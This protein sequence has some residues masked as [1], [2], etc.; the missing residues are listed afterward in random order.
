MEYKANAESNGYN[1]PTRR[2]SGGA[3]AVASAYGISGGNAYDVT[4]KKIKNNPEARG[5]S[6]LHIM[7]F[8]NKRH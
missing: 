4:T 7:I 3:G 1:N 8:N 2:N 5:C 6:S